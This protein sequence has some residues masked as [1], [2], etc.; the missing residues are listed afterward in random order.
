M[1]NSILR[2]Q[3]V[4][5]CTK[6]KPIFY[7][8]SFDVLPNTIHT[9]MG[10]SGI[11]KSTLLKCLNRL[12]ELQPNLKVSGNILFRNKDIFSMQVEKIRKKMGMVFQAPVIFPGTIERNVLFGV[13]HL[14]PEKK[15]DFPAILEMSLTEAAL[16]DEVKDRL[17][18]KA[19]TLSVGQKQRLS[20]ARV[21]ALRPDVL[22]LDEPTSALD[23]RA[24]ELIE[25]LFLSLKSIH[26]LILVTHDV[27][28]AERISDTVV[29]MVWKNGGGRMLEKAQT[30]P[31]PKDVL[32]ETI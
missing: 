19:E 11:G 22:L 26:T 13:R 9:I 21:L 5:V 25:E 29:Q 32:V 28:Q 1:N 23:P 17:H 30:A 16:W 7:P 31:L 10:P 2:L 4:S 27:T 3:N 6:G 8:L 18:E 14:M 15:K 12:T 24:T 20:I